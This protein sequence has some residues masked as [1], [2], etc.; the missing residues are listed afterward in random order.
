MSPSPAQVDA[1]GRLRHLITLDGLPGRLLES[2]LDRAEP[3]TRA[4]IRNDALAGVT[5]ANLF[6]EPS[7]RTQTR[8][9]MPMSSASMRRR[10]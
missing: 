10:S 9:S 2:L 6:G 5:V 1:A 7:T 3:F 8:P 4:P